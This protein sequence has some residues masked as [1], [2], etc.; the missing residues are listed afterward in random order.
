[1]DANNKHHCH[2]HY[3][4]A[5]DAHVLRIDHNAE[6]KQF[7]PNFLTR[8]EPPR[9]GRKVGPKIAHAGLCVV[10]RATCVQ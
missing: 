6:A 1:M 10:A 2:V 3:L 5:I 4:E 9:V 7:G 8:P